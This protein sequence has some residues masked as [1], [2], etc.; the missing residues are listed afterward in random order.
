MALNNN[1]NERGGLWNRK[2]FDIFFSF[3]MKALMVSHMNMENCVTD[4]RV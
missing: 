1:R 4:L 3:F 2:I